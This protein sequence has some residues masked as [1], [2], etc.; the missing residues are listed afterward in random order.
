VSLTELPV[1]ELLHRF[2]SADPTPGG[3]S[4]AALGGAIGA[5]LAAM[6]CAMPKTRTGAPEERARL[7]AAGAVAAAAAQRLRELVDEDT[8]AYNGVVAAYRL[9]KATDAEKAARKQAIAAAMRRATDVPMA[10]ARQCL[11][12]MESAA[13]AARVGN[14]N[15][16]SDALSGQALAWAGL[17]GAA[18]NVR[19]NAP[20]LG[21]AGSGAADL[22]AVNEVL[23]AGRALLDAALAG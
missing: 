8:D 5:S 13:T 14:P 11:A 10:T 12:V 15:A 23:Q 2:A 9:A 4:A 22:A 19:A 3:G 17:M 1:L 7:D 20:S 21:D 6:V 16:T 18:Q